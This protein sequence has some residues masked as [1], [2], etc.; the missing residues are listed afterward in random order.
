M[1]NPYFINT[2][3][4]DVYDYLQLQALAIFNDPYDT[5]GWP[6][7]GFHPG[8]ASL[9]APHNIVAFIDTP[10]PS[11]ELYEVAEKGTPVW[12]CVGDQYEW[13]W[14]V[15]NMT[16]TELDAFNADRKLTVSFTRRTLYQIETDP[17]MGQVLREEI[18]MQQ[19]KDKV[20]EI[21]TNNPYLPI[22][23]LPE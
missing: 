8:L 10:K 4:K 9:L 20:E 2:V 14:V 16:Q 3:T 13:N 6:N 21:R 1:P 23:T 12:K 18:T 11:M 22:V 15:R 19:Y 7:D 17:M 5:P